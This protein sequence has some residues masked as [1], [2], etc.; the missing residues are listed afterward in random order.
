METLTELDY[1]LF[2]FWILSGLCVLIFFIR[3]VRYKEPDISEYYR[4]INQLND[5]KDED[6]KLL[7][8]RNN[9]IDKIEEEIL[10]CKKELGIK[11]F[12]KKD[13]NF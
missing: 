5:Q 12:K 8:E 4:L 2:L 7:H 10:K 3:K 11:L 13:S 6:L 9:E 1:L